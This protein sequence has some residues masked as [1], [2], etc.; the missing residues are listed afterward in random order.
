[1][2]ACVHTTL[3]FVTNADFHQRASL[4]REFDSLLVGPGLGLCEEQWDNPKNLLSNFE[5]LLVLD[6]DG[7]NRLAQSRHSLQTFA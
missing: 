1:M 3:A 2:C 5:G 7:I 6:A 4:A